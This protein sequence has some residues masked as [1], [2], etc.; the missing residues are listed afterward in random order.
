[1]HNYDVYNRDIV[2]DRLT[3]LQK[4]LKY[5]NAEM[6]MLLHVSERTYQRLKSKTCKQTQHISGE[7]LYYLHQA[8]IDTGYLL[9]FSDDKSMRLPLNYFL[10]I[11]KDFVGSLEPDEKNNAVAAIMNELA[12]S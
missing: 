2:A 7:S 3:A 1:M 10:I 5:N 11:M 12:K 4:S 8:G 6:A 9:G